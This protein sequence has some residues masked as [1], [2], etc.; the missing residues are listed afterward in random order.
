MNWS[1]SYAL[2]GAG[3]YVIARPTPVTTC[4]MKTASVALPS[5]YHHPTGRSSSRGTGW[6]RTAMTESSSSKRSP[7]HVATR[8]GTF[9]ASRS[10]L[11]P[12]SLS[13]AAAG[14]READR[15]SP[16]IRVR[17]GHGVADRHEL[18]LADREIR[19][20]AH[21]HEL[22]GRRAKKWREEIPEDGE[23]DDPADEGGERK[24]DERE[25]PS[26]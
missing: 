20:R 12:A 13:G 3:T 5:T 4:A 14:G 23:T 6:R 11:I 10:R 17:R 22:V 15:R 26:A 1:E 25:E 9:P 24:R 16:A 2:F 8:P 18:R 21:R 19:D 7:S